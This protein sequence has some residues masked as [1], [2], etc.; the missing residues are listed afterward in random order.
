MGGSALYFALAASLL[1]PVAVVA[2]V[3]RE[4]EPL[5]REAVAGRPIDLERL[6]V[7]DAPT[8][9]WRASDTGGGNVDLGRDDRIYDVWRP[10]TE[11]DLPRCPG[12]GARHN[13]EP[14]ECKAP[15][16]VEPGTLV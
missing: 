3:G 12:A 14:G 13:T 4:D 9:R 6:A 5:V 1:T 8:F 2:A 10:R 11:A 7:L 16:R 15:I